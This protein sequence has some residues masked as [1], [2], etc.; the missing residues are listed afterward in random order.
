[1]LLGYVVWGA[2]TMLLNFDM[3]W[4]WHVDRGKHM[5]ASNEVYICNLMSA[6]M[7]FFFKGLYN[8]SL[9][10]SII[11]KIS[12]T[13]KWLQIVFS[14]FLLLSSKIM[15]FSHNTTSVLHSFTIKFEIIQIFKMWQFTIYT[16]LRWNQCFKICR[17]LYTNLVSLENWSYFQF[18]TKC[19]ISIF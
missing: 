13:Y 5:V 10:K 1:M 12:H 8:I 11:T 4:S 7:M 19:K 9:F 14:D 6:Y 3:T 17:N 18:K 16:K 15:G 2:H